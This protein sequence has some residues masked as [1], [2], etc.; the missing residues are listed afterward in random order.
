[1][2]A[3]AITEPVTESVEDDEIVSE[4]GVAAETVVT[5]VEAVANQWM[6]Y[7]RFLILEI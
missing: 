6:C 2:V 1:M 5:G 4:V 3:E 7:L